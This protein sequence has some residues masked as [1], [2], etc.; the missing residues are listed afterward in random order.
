MFRS[1][2]VSR[3]QFE[4]RLRLFYWRLCFCSRS[5]AQTGCEDRYKKCRLLPSSDNCKCARPHSIATFLLLT[6]THTHTGALE[7]ELASVEENLSQLERMAHKVVAGI[8]WETRQVR[9]EQ[10]E[11]DSLWEN[12]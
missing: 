6:H 9:N 5:V 8:R 12:L 4:R 2:C 10:E 7:R 1:L 3:V 11:I